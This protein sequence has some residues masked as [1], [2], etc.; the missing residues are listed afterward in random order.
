[1]WAEKLKRG[2]FSVDFKCPY[3]EPKKGKNLSQIEAGCIDVWP[4]I[5]NICTGNPSQPLILIFIPE[6]AIKTSLNASRNDSK[7]SQIQMTA[8]LMANQAYWYN[9]NGSNWEI[10]LLTAQKRPSEPLLLIRYW[11]QGL[12]WPNK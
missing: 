8:I 11:F 12:K 4:K 9:K 2:F 5:A 3:F 7:I 6:I 10:V 1:M